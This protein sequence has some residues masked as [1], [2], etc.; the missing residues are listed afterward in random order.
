MG[1]AVFAESFNAAL[2]DRFFAFDNPPGR[3][4]EL[5]RQ[6]LKLSVT[7]WWSEV[8]RR[9]AFAS[10]SAFLGQAMKGGFAE[11]DTDLKATL[12]HYGVGAT[13]WEASRV[14]MGVTRADRRLDQATARAAKE[15]FDTWLWDRLVVTTLPPDGPDHARFGRGATDLTGEGELLRFIAQFR[16]VRM[17]FLP[18]PNATIELREADRAMI[19]AMASGDG[20]PTLAGLLDWTVLFA[21]LTRFGFDVVE[22]DAPAIGKDEWPWFK[23]ALVGGAFGFCADIL[24]GDTTGMK[25]LPLSGLAELNHPSVDSALRLWRR[26]R[27]RDD[28]RGALAAWAEREG[29]ANALDTLQMTRQALNYALLHQLQD[30]ISPGYLQRAVKDT[31]ARAADAY[32]RMPGAG[33]RSDGGGTLN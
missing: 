25:V 10:L 27:D 17:P 23:S 11:A 3:T 32:W 31:E 7:Y 19:Q 8:T 22:G 26:A 9:A 16:T 12:S 6:F 5:L 28:V 14:L 18:K 24:F 21:R 15:K 2:M 4:A 13:D 33:D 20:L 1:I 29:D 30:M